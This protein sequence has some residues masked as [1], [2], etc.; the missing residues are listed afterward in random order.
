MTIEPHL[1]ELP[2]EPT[3]LLR[4]VADGEVLGA[5]RQ[6]HVLGECLVALVG[7]RGRDVT[8]L[9][10][11]VRAIEEYVRRTRGASSQAVS[12]GLALMARPA[13]A[14]AES[15]CDDAVGERLLAA[16]AAFRAELSGWQLAARDHA[17]EL[18][19]A[20]RTILVYDYS[21][22]VS[23]T[24][25]EL[26]RSG[27]LLQLFVPEARSLDGGRK[28]LADWHALDIV[29]D[30]VPDSAVGW[31]LD[32]CDVALAGA[33]TLSA[34][35][36]CYNTIG[37]AIAAHQANL[38]QVPFHV[39]SILLKTHLGTSGAERPI[40]ILDFLSLPHPAGRPQA[41]PLVTLR[42]NFPDLDYTAP[43]AITSIVTE[44]GCLDPG[45]VA[46][47]A[48]AVLSDPEPARD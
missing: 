30:L 8:R 20:C 17:T 45:E 21:S 26:A 28:Y 15:R 34:E 39:L 35:G 14:A 23:Q 41:S 42:G 22:S 37:T 29:V 10:A 43:A 3:R 44:L 48:R 46:T 13:L 31:A 9:S 6:L 38:R 47:A 12:N 24:V 11:D 25:V 33:E 19:G 5:S 18:L 1:P 7:A 16:V 4:T 36:G 40:P 32:Q 27:R 2:N